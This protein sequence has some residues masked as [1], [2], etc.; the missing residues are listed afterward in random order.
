LPSQKLQLAEAPLVE[1]ITGSRKSLLSAEINGVFEMAT[2]PINRGSKTPLISADSKD[3]LLPV[4]FSTR[5]ASASKRGTVFEN[6]TGSRKSLLSAEI[7]GVF[8]MATLP[9]NRGGHVDFVRN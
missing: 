5:G 8:E 2:L 4:I 9:I 7:N 1:N 3:F 6:I